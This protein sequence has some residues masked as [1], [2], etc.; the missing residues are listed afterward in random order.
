[1]PSKTSQLPLTARIWVTVTGSDYRVKRWKKLSDAAKKNVDELA[2]HIPADTYQSFNKDYDLFIRSF[3][4]YDECMD[5]GNWQMATIARTTIF[6]F[7]PMLSRRGVTLSGTASTLKKLCVNNHKNVPKIDGKCALCFA[8]E[9]E[10]ISVNSSVVRQ[11]VTTPGPLPSN[12]PTPTDASL[13]NVTNAENPSH[14]NILASSSSVAPSGMLADIK[15]DGPEV[16]WDFVRSLTQAPPSS[17]MG[18]RKQQT[19][20]TDAGEAVVD[21]E[22]MTTYLNR[23]LTT[24]AFKYN[25]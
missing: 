11:V 6:N 24:F 9:F 21:N 25:Q 3:N 17:A 13:T 18:Q 12:A 2:T 15:G 23:G 20:S 16:P 4:E 8:T 19:I 1:M 10:G 7:G 5:S 22:F 14:A